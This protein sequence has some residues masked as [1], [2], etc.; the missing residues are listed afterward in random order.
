MAVAAIMT[1]DYAGVYIPRI[2]KELGVNDNYHLK[3][4]HWVLAPCEVKIVE[5]YNQYF[6]LLE[7]EDTVRVKSEFGEYDLLNNKILEQRYEHQGK[8]TISN[9]SSVYKHIKF[10]QVIP[11][12]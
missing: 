6:F 12:Q 2:M 5:G 9:P 8:I 3:F 1:I 4:K 7:A 11:I 10:F